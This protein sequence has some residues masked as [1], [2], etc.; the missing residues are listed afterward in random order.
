MTRTMLSVRRVLS[1]GLT[2]LAGTAC[3]ACCAVP[4]LLAAGV[5]SGAGWA[6]AGRWMP[7]APGARAVRVEALRKLTPRERVAVAAARE[8]LEVA[9]NKQS[10]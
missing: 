6:I 10:D 9:F 5:L 4:A 8:R 1:A 2:G 7:A 3:L